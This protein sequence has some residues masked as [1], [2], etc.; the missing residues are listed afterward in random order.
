MVMKAVVASASHLDPTSALGS[1]AELIYERYFDTLEAMA[2][3]KATPS[4][5]LLPWPL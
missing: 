3:G 1:Q 2:I 4:F 5:K